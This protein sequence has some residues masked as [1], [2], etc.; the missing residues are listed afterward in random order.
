MLRKHVGRVSRPSPAMIVAI[1]ALV[2]ACAGTATAAG[3]FIRSSSQLGKNVVTS[4]AIKDHS[5]LGADIKA[6]SITGDLIKSGSI[7]PSKLAASAAGVGGGP[8]ALEAYN[9]QGPVV[10]NGLQTVATLKGIPAGAWAIFA[11]TVITR[12]TPSNALL[13]AG[14]TANAHCVLNAQGDTTEAGGP[15]SGNYSNTEAD[16][17][18]QITRTFPNVSDV[19]LTCDA[20]VSWQA[21]GTSII[22]IKLASA[23]RTQ[24]GG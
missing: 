22:A 11:T 17:H 8:P 6:R 21:G 2:V 18:L 3:V 19:S 20:P 24:V 5:V 1:V 7:D 4:K 12:Q 10:N 13:Q 14:Q 23:A 16:L 9:H 15:L